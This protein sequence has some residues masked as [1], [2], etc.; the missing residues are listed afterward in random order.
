M[1][2]YARFRT[3]SARPRWPRG[4]T[5]AATVSAAP[6]RTTRSSGAVAAGHEAVARVG[7]EVLD[8]GGNAVDAVVAMVAAGGVCEPTLTSIAGGGFMIVGGGADNLDPVLI[9]FFV[10]QPG[11]ERRPHLA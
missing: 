7:A 4:P 9:D 11:L 2:P 3:M 10:R 6:G 8:R 5:G 1:L